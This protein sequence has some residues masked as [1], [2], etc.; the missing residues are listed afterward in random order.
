MHKKSGK[1]FT[2]PRHREAHL[3]R[4][5]FEALESRE[6]F[7]VVITTWT[8][9]HGDGDWNNVFNWSN[10]LPAGLDVIAQFIAPDDFHRYPQDNFIRLN[11]DANLAGIFVEGATVGIALNGH[12]M[13]VHTI[14]V[15]SDASGH[16]GNLGLQQF[17]GI[18]KTVTVD[19]VSVATGFEYSH[20]ELHVSGD[21]ITLHVLAGLD[22]ATN[23]YTDGRLNVES[24][25]FVN[26][27]HEGDADPTLTTFGTNAN[28]CAWI[29]WSGGGILATETVYIDGGEQG[30]TMEGN[31]AN[32]Q[33]NGPVYWGEGARDLTKWTMGAGAA[34]VLNGEN[35]YLA[36][37]DAFDNNSAQDPF[38][39]MAFEDDMTGSFKLLLALANGG[40]H[41]TLAVFG[42][43]GWGG[44]F[45]DVLL[46]FNPYGYGGTI[47]AGN[48]FPVAVA[49]TYSGSFSYTDGEDTLDYNWEDPL[50]DEAV[51]NLPEIHALT[52][53][54]LWRQKGIL[55][56][57]GS[58]MAV[59]DYGDYGEEGPGDYDTAVMLAVVYNDGYYGEG[60]QRQATMTVPG[61]YIEQLVAG[62]PSALAAELV[63]GRMIHVAW[64]SDLVNVTAFLIQ[65]KTDDGDWVT[66]QMTESYVNWWMDT[67]VHKGHTYSYRV[68]ALD[69]DNDLESE[70]TTLTAAIVV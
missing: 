53:W 46:G 6:L 29:W 19:Y 20:A 21:K 32:W 64:E 51:A 15:E 23:D 31:A 40:Y 8:G 26:V 65:R 63:A 35:Y 25:A 48:M 14:D 34:G 50:P 55:G 4:A 59:G 18:T 37:G 16:M 69:Q 57:D 36:P 41:S 27:V 2:R 68:M 12:V 39:I 17:D 58:F 66:I 1:D 47:M 30:T 60:A 61:E 56:E 52:H 62:V 22:V 33:K 70:Y 28:S 38:A 9:G 43:L 7:D 24:G 11:E 54:I 45:A 5:V 67:N 44:A 10:G 3:W 13:R 49:N 42:D